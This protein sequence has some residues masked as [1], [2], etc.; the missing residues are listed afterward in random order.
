MSIHERI[1]RPSLGSVANFRACALVAAFPIM[2][3]GGCG[4]AERTLQT[5]P[6]PVAVDACLDE[7]E[8]EGQ[9]VSRLGPAADDVQLCVVI[10]GLDCVFM[11]RLCD[12]AD[13]GTPMWSCPSPGF[14]VEAGARLDARLFIVEDPDGASACAQIALLD[15]PTCTETSCLARI[16]YQLEYSS[17]D[18]QPLTIAPAP[19]RIFHSGFLSEEVG[20]FETG[21]ASICGAI[22]D[23][24]CEGD[25]CD[26]P[27]RLEV[28]LQGIGT[29]TVSVAS[30]ARSLDCTEGRCTL[31]LPS[32]RNVT[33]TSSAAEGSVFIDW[34]DACADRQREATCTFQPSGDTR[35]TARFGYRLGIEILGE[36]Q[37]LSSDGGF[38]GTGIN[39]SADEFG[40]R[41]EEDYAAQREV[42]LVA[43]G[44]LDWPF[45]RWI[46]CDDVQD[47][48]CT[49]TMDRAREV[50][51]IFGRQI[52]LRVIGGG[53]MTVAPGGQRC[54]DTCTFALAPDEQVTLTASANALSTLYDW[55]GDCAATA[56][57][58]C[59]LGALDRNVETTVRFGYD[60]T[61]AFD[62]AQGQVNVEAVGGVPCATGVPGCRAY[63]PATM[64]TLTAVAAV[65][66]AHAFIGWSGLCAS[67]ADA[68][69]CT[70]SVA[71]G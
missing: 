71:E 4:S 34:G 23:F 9:P 54:T 52:S 35:V 57:D 65:E 68:A 10:Q 69:S 15:P 11:E 14:E 37:V 64:V 55:L 17:D 25:G 61:P 47:N 22:T 24:T 63:L 67:F 30:A 44:T 62:A 13:C 45:S 12:D 21:P 50:R 5:I 38:D 7:L 48:V 8:A 51:A 29:G 28:E 66:P 16:D 46:G 27:T 58:V 70:L 6:I 32:D 59:D 40:T 33:L 20:T 19:V 26:A 53:A 42:D 3:V 60:V 1:V 56:G 43:E 36:G 49:V 41:C 18:E 31:F 39:C 2:V